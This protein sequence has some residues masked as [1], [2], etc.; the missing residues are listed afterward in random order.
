MTTIANFWAAGPV[1]MP[2][3][4]LASPGQ[5]QGTAGTITDSV[6]LSAQARLLLGMID[7]LAAGNPLAAAASRQPQFFGPPGLRLMTPVSAEIVGAGQ[8]TAVSGG[9][10]DAAGASI[11]TDPAEAEGTV[12]RVTAAASDT[13]GPVGVEIRA[14]ATDDRIRAYAVAGKGSASLGIDAG[15]GTNLIS[16]ATTGSLTIMAGAGNDE[17]AA[18][19]GAL[20]EIDLG[21]GDNLVTLI[22]NLGTLRSGA[23]NDTIA[24]QG[25]ATTVASGAGNDT[26]SGAQWV[27]AGRGDDS[28]LLGNADLNTLAFRRGDG[29]DEITLAG[30]EYG[31]RATASRA[32]I[33]DDSGAFEA[34]AIGIATFGGFRLAVPQPGE[35][36]HGASHAA[37][38]LQDIA[39]EEVTASL[40]GTDLTLTMTA[41]GAALGAASGD[42]IV[43]H[44]YSAGRVSFIFDNREAGGGLSATRTLPGLG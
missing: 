38:V 41:S 9:G 10:S 32:V 43:I 26:I 3:L 29:A 35:D 44:N 16:A 7:L 24:V 15:A 33:G 5:S 40:D 8:L 18:T 19:F 23:G 20:G 6:E 4:G 1:T 39:L 17:V 42:R 27:N 12:T 25:N 36:G 13:G 14:T 28:I 34:Q 30:A 22:G 37:L 11:E 31:A 2:R 21:D